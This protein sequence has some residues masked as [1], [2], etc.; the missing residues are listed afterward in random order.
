MAAIRAP[1]FDALT[2]K[3]DRPAKHLGKTFLG[4]TSTSFFSSENSCYGSKQFSETW[5]QFSDP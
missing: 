5:L 2:L 3:V 1:G 4:I